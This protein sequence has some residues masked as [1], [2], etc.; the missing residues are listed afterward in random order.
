MRPLAEALFLIS[1]PV[2]RISDTAMPVASCIVPL[3]QVF[4]SSNF[5]CF[6]QACCFS[7]IFVY[8]TTSRL[9]GLDMGKII[10]VLLELA[11][12]FVTHVSRLSCDQ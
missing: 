8:C 2:A 12:A 5:A 10:A 11:E 4:H 7:C 6:A 1:Q 3:H 9:R